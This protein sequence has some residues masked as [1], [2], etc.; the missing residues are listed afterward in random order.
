MCVWELN[1]RHA[2]NATHAPVAWN[3]AKAEKSSTDGLQELKSTA[4]FRIFK[5]LLCL[6]QIVTSRFQNGR[7]RRR[8]RRVGK[9]RG[10]VSTFYHSSIFYRFSEEGGTLEAKLEAEL[11]G[12]HFQK[13]SSSSFSYPFKYW[14]QIYYLKIKTRTPEYQLKFHLD[15]MTKSLELVLPK[16]KLSRKKTS[17]F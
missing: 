2:R 8:R 5:S 7:R 1:R 14:I 9:K 3:G 13:S 16:Q 4:L 17:F 15:E 11:F 10:R 6:G 12:G